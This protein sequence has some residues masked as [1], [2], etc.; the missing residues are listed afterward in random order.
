MQKTN[1]LNELLSRRA[2]VGRVS[3]GGGRLRHPDKTTFVLV[4]FLAARWRVGWLQQTWADK[5]WP[6]ES[7]WPEKDATSRSR[8]QVRMISMIEP[9]ANQFAFITSATS[10]T[11]PLLPAETG[12]IFNI[13]R[14]MTFNLIIAPLLK[15][16]VCWSNVAAY[17]KS[18]A[19]RDDLVVMWLVTGIFGLFKMILHRF[20]ESKPRIGEDSSLRKV[21]WLIVVQ[22]TSGAVRSSLSYKKPSTIWRNCQREEWTQKLVR[23]SQKQR[24]AVVDNMKFCYWRMTVWSCPSFCCPVIPV[25][26]IQMLCT[27]KAQET[28]VRTQQ[29]HTPF[30][31]HLVIGLKFWVLGLLDETEIQSNQRNSLNQQLPVRSILLGKI[32][33][34][35]WWRRCDCWG[36][37]GCHWGFWTAFPTPGNSL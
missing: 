29:E 24:Q 6:T 23:L 7:Q 8:S 13:S 21:L 33:V 35:P 25:P 20:E 17:D 27:V 15:V 5:P 10:S 31:I 37:G 3:V 16:R 11:N 22:P 28:A 1:F 18:K 2:G 9:Q 30:I 32:R 14:L 26:Q 12:F 4:F 34:D 36:L 19:F